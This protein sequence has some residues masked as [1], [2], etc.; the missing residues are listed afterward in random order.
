MNFT[1]TQKMLLAGVGVLTAVAAG[2]GTVAVLG[3]RDSHS[4]ARGSHAVDAVIEAP[5]TT[6]AL[7]PTPPNAVTPAGDDNGAG[8]SSSP[9]GG[10]PAGGGAADPGAGIGAQDPAQDPGQGPAQGAPGSGLGAKLPQSN[11]PVVANP[12]FALADTTGPKLTIA[13]ISCTPFTVLA[14]VNVNDPSGIASVSAVFASTNLL[15]QPNAVQTLTVNQILTGVYSMSWSRGKWK[16]SNLAIAA[17]DSLENK[18]VLNKTA[19]CSN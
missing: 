12:Q 15:D 1:R 9:D 8:A 17:R 16:T 3:T 10:A 19:L 13:D 4:A 18:T 2:L 7:A 5:P 14:I 11:I 6:I